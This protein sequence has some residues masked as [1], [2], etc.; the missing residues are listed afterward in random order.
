[1]FTAIGSIS[2]GLTALG[3]T[4]TSEQRDEQQKQFFH[5][6]DTITHEFHDKEQLNSNG[7]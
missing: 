2:H 4:D 6:P 5:E 7:D 3:E 1:M